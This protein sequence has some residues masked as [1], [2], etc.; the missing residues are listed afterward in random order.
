MNEKFFIYS[1][2]HLLRRIQPF[3]RSLFSKI[4][5]LALPVSLFDE[6]NNFFFFFS[7]AE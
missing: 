7:M 5:K 2:F 6:H 4:N 1:S 3:V